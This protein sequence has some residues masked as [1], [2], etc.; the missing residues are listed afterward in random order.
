M[1][2][3]FSDENEKLT[4]EICDLMQRA[5]DAALDMEF[6]E[7][8]KA[9]GLKSGDVKAEISVSVVSSDE[10]CEINREFRGIGSATDVLSFPQ[11][12]NHDSLLGDLLTEP[13]GAYVPIGDVVICYDKALSQAEEYET[14]VKR[15]LLYLF[16]HSIMHLFGYDHMNEEDKKEM[17]EHEEKV[18]AEIGVSR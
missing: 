16:V 4:S 2:L 10:I 11:Y 1:N 18:L 12:D 8:L 7:D 15:E 9:E 14:G 5:A 17:R 3:I 13:E 6:G